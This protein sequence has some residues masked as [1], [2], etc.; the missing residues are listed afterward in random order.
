MQLRCLSMTVL[1]A[2]PDT[3][4]V[5]SDWITNVRSILDSY[6]TNVLFFAKLINNCM[7]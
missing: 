7:P 1:M 3:L 4:H 2:K 6:V 5:T